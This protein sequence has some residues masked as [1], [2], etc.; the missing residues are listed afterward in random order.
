[1]PLLGNITRGNGL[2]P[3]WLTDPPPPDQSDP[4]SGAHIA[5]KSPHRCRVQKYPKKSGHL[6][7]NQATLHQ[8]D[9]EA[10]L[11]YM[12][13]K[14]ARILDGTCPRGGAKSQSSRYGR[15]L[16]PEACR[17]ERAAFTH[18][19]NT[20]GERERP[21]VSTRNCQWRPR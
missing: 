1:M 19:V 17:G 12:S 11:R 4:R 5:V 14:A 9:F 8:V 7:R 10:Q 2:T 21:N 20:L 16:T 15:I 13:K 3:P 6:G 18:R